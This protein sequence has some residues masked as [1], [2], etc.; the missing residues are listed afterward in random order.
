MLLKHGAFSVGNISGVVTAIVCIAATL[1][2]WKAR[3]SELG[4]DG[5]I[6]LAFLVTVIG[7]M[8][9]AAVYRAFV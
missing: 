1:R 9:I 3:G 2:Y 5:K 6:L 7:V 4:A 8:T